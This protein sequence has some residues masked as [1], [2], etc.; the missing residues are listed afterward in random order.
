M[1]QI[2][3]VFAVRCLMKLETASIYI[4]SMTKRLRNNELLN[5][6][7]WAYSSHYLTRVEEN[8]IW[9]A[10]LVATVAKLEYWPV[11]RTENAVPT[12][13]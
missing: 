10:K 3:R 5:S 4:E 9:G 6:A 2:F 11:R 12:G 13:T 7:T 1:M 8:N